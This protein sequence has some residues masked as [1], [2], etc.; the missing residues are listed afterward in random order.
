MADKEGNKTGGRV[1]GIPNKPTQELRELA[2][3]LG[4]NPFEILLMFAKAD[5]DGLGIMEYRTIKGKDGST[6]QEPTISPELRQK[7]AKD[8]CEYLFPKLKQVEIND[9]GRDDAI[10][11]TLEAFLKKV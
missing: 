5:Y 6:F 11:E 4:V 1:K 9:P 3:K 7:A 2:D 10:K 8:A